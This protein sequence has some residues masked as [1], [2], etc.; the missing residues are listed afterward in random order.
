LA[1]LNPPAPI[2]EQAYFWKGRL[3]YAGSNWEGA[4]E[5]L[6]NLN[7]LHPRS[8]LADASLFFAARA[9]R[10]ASDYDRATKL[11]ETLAREHPG[12]AFIEQAEIEAAESMIEA[13]RADAAAR[14]FERFI[15]NN[16]DSPLR[17]LALYD[18]GKALQRA[19]EF[20]RAI[21]QYRAAA[22]GET[23]E[24]AARCR[25][26]IAECLAELDLGGKATAE[27]IGIAQGGFPKG[28]AERARL[29][30]ARLLERDNRMD[31]ARQVYS[32]IAAEFADDA[33]GMVALKAME[34]IDSDVLT[35]A[36]R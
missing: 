36:E 33:A 4:I 5:S 26:A 6:L 27:L 3:D 11:F 1:D 8:A 17:P 15:K 34:R 10:K 28:W 14:K 32:V 9:A 16:L 25:F 7:R 23:T 35:A 13:G 20:E 29:Q 18:M 21:E 22:G 19:G 30:F 12:S 24:L 31:E 2:A